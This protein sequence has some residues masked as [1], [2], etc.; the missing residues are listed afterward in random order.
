MIKNLGVFV[1]ICLLLFHGRAFAQGATEKTLTINDIQCPNS[2]IIGKALITDVCWEAMF[3]IYIGGVNL[4]GKSRYAPADRNKNRLCSCAGSLKDGTLPTAG[5]SIGMY[6]PKYLLTV[7]KKPYCFPELNGTELASKLGL[8]SRYNV[9][10]E[11]DSDDDGG[12]SSNDVSYSWHLSALPLTKI[13]EL[14]NTLGCF[15]DGYSTFD[16]LWISETLPMW[17]DSELAFY[18]APESMIFATPLALA[19]MVTD[20]LSSTLLSPMDSLFFVAGCWGSMYPLSGSLGAIGDKVAG[21]SLIAARALFFLSRIGVLERTMG[22]D[23]VCRNRKMP[24]MKKSQYRFQ[25]LWPMSE[26][27]SMDVLCKDD[28]GC[29]NKTASTT[30]GPEKFGSNLNKNKIEQIAIN[31]INK[32]CA[33]PIGQSTFNWG[34]WRD[35]KQAD[36]ASYLIFQWNDCCGDFVQTVL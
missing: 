1:V 34:I 3:P 15:S 13:L 25:Q 4:K 8:V 35:A 36:F 20:C 11:D 14:F 26:S 27:E 21:K 29:D 28:K 19:G 24:I 12:G 16:I 9:G 31:S 18:V 17:Y 33:H 2:K 5:T 10:N 30:L 7:T 32:T 22:S 23:A 6:L